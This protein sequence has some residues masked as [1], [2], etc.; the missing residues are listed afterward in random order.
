[1]ENGVCQWSIALVIA[2][3]LGHIFMEIGHPLDVDPDSYV[4]TY[5]HKHRGDVARLQHLLWD[6]VRPGILLNIHKKYVGK[7]CFFRISFAEETRLEFSD[8]AQ[9]SLP[10]LNDLRCVLQ[11]QD[12][13]RFSY[14]NYWNTVRVARLVTEV[15]PPFPNDIWSPYDRSG[16]LLGIRIKGMV[17]V[18]GG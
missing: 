15:L 6:K 14:P 8:F 1:M 3:I 5:L 10:F 4:S 17:Y 12:G 16:F 9:T 7:N 2:L 13:Q 18:T 11:E